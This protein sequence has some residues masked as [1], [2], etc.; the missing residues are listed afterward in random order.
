MLMFSMPMYEVQYHE[1]GVWREI[2]ELELMDDLYR[3]YKKVTPAIKEM[4][5][6]NEI[7]TPYGRY[8]L[9]LKGGPSEK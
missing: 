8:R 7:E 6:G 1:D 5:L 4:I 9:K 2:S 3:M